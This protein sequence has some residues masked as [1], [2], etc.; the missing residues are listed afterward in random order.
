MA[1]SGTKPRVPWV[2]T[3][4]GI[5]IILVVLFHSGNWSVVAFDGAS[6]WV[7][8]NR[9][10]ASLR[11]PL[12]FTLSGL[13]A[14]K[15]VTASWLS[16]WRHKLSLFTWVYLLWSTI[17]TF[18]FMLG[19]SVQD[20]HGNFLKA[21]TKGW[22]FTAVAPRFEYWF[23]WALALF[24]VL[25][26]LTR[27]VPAWIQLTAAGSLSLVA[28]SGV[29]LV[30]VG[31]TG[32][33]KYLFFFLL[34]LHAR[35]S[36]R[37][38]GDVNVWVLA[39]P[40]A[41]WACLVVSGAAFGW[42]A[43][44]PGY[45]F[46]TSVVGLFAGILLSRAL[47]RLTFVQYLGRNTLPIYLTHTT[48]ILVVVWLIH[49]VGTGSSTPIVGLAFV[50]TLATVALLVSLRLGVMSESRPALRFLYA[51]PEWFQSWWPVPWRTGRGQI[52]TRRA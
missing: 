6:T 7:E 21:A 19:M 3:G 50:P 2:D 30:N 14:A 26:K 28:L 29:T 15:W 5:A 44:V 4:R 35:D 52:D 31:W 20:Q 12:F 17:G 42:D 10:L 33:A 45:Y 37:R 41:L 32:M 46:A 38:L 27:R 34:G 25:V 48:I 23:I 51:A 49:R 47:S 40:A 18:V 13:F 43:S 9:A 16:L 39:P 1:G 8:V 11:M 24:F 22:L 36:I